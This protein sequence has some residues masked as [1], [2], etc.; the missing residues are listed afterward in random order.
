MGV[1]SQDTPPLTPMLPSIGTDVKYQIKCN[2]KFDLAVDAG[3]NLSFASSIN[4]GMIIN[5]QTNY[6]SMYIQLTQV[7]DIGFANSNDD[8]AFNYA[9]SLTYCHRFENTI[10]ELRLPAVYDVTTSGL[11]IRPPILSIGVQ[12]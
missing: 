5:N 4:L 3:I 11:T 12:L 8:R 6:V 7:P 1:N 10:L 9:Y 2:N